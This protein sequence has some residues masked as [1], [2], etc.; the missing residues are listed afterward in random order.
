MRGGEVMPEFIKKYLHQIKEFWKSLDKSQKTRLYVTS[1]IVIVAVSI[2]IFVLTRPNRIVL[3]SDSNQ[4]QIG[5][6]IAVLNDNGI[7]NSAGNNGTSII[8]NSKDNDNAQILLAQAGYPKEGFTFEDAISQIGITTTQSDKK[9]I[10]KRQQISDLET[11]IELLDNIDEAAVTLTT[12]E[13]SF[14]KAEG[15]EQPR[16]TAYVM[17]RPNTRLTSSQVEGI[18]MLVSRSVERLN[19][20][21]VTVADNNSNILNANSGDESINAANSQEELRLK[22]EKELEQKVLDYFSVGQ[23]DNFDTLRVVAN[24]TLDF[25]K[26]K[27][28]TKSIT[29]PE[30]MDGGAVISSKTSEEKVKNGTA[31]GE[32]GLDANP[33]DTNAPSYQIGSNTNSDYSNKQAETNYGYDEQLRETEKATGKLIP[34]ESGI[35]IFLW[36]GKRVVDDS[37]MG[38]DFLNEIKVATSTAT[39]VPL[40]NISVSKMKMAQSE[41]I[42]I[43]TGEKIRELISDYGFFALILILVIILLIAGIPRRKADEQEVMQPAI[44]GG[45]KFVIPEH[46]DPLPDIE[47]EERSEIKKQ[48]DKFVKQKPDSVAQLL[49]NWLSDEWEG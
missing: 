16:P 11:K 47:L 43:T 30:G 31:S 12:P 7:R 14:F 34:G 21:D 19:P 28:Q 13:A 25:D 2:S 38:D 49:R 29:N 36:Y 5:E 4:K 1:F 6:M 45:P 17:I 20:K 35:G 18:V 32:P 40:K 15:Q 22:R 42:E 3:F 8:I 33:G 48:I 41:V 46:E 37:K 27:L 44:A 26:D 23:F 9:F 10:W 24:A 39:G